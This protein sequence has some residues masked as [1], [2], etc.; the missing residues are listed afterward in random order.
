MAI[1]D[2]NQTGIQTINPDSLDTGAALGQ[3]NAQ[4]MFE[5]PLNTD[6]L[7][8]GAALGQAN[9]SELVSNFRQSFS[10]SQAFEYLSDAYGYA[11]PTLPQEPQAYQGPIEYQR[12]D[13][14]QFYSYDGRVLPVPVELSPDFDPYSFD[15]LGETDLSYRFM[16]PELPSGIEAIYA[17]TERDPFRADWMDAEFRDIIG[18]EGELLEPELMNVIQDAELFLIS[19][20]QEA[21]SQGFSS[22]E[23]FLRSLEIND[24]NYFA[25]LSNKVNE[26]ASLMGEFGDRYRFQTSLYEAQQIPTEF[27]SESERIQMG[28]DTLR[29]LVSLGVYTPEEAA[30]LASNPSGLLSLLNQEDPAATT[31]NTNNQGISNVEEVDSQDKEVD[32]QVG[33]VDS[34]GRQIEYPL[35]DENKEYPFVFDD[36]INQFVPALNENQRITLDDNGMDVI[37]TTDPNTQR[38]SE[39]KSLNEYP[40]FFS[41]DMSGASLGAQ[42]GAEFGRTIDESLIAP[43]NNQ[44]VYDL[45]EDYSRSPENV[46]SMYFSDGDYGLSTSDLIDELT[47]GFSRTPVFDMNKFKPASE[48]EFN[49]A[50]ADE[51]VSVTRQLPRT[52]PRPGPPQYETTYY[53]SMVPKSDLEYESAG[54]FDAS[55]ENFLDEHVNNIFFDL[56]GYEENNNQQS[57]RVFTRA[58]GFRQFYDDVDVQSFMLQEM[59]DYLSQTGKSLRSV[60]FQEKED[61]ATGSDS[62][63]IFDVQSFVFGNEDEGWDGIFEK[64]KTEFDTELSDY[65]SEEFDTMYNLQR[66]ALMTA[67]L[68]YPIFSRIDE[69][70]NSRLAGNDFGGLSIASSYIDEFGN[71]PQPDYLDTALNLAQGGYIGGIA[72]GMDDTIPATVDGSNPAALS[73][74][75]FVIPADVVSHLGDGNN[76]NGAQ[77]LYGFLDDVRM[78]KT[79]SIEQPAPIND[80]IFASAMGEDYGF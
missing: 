77:K 39:I 48:A 28:M 38:V 5:T 16:Q 1:E 56:T 26:S 79:G 54:L 53:I 6:S 76:Q 19:L 52:G 49:L 36:S 63:D 78:S 37:V 12:P 60:A 67:G 46:L 27:R 57:E 17:P 22:T 33:E 70:Y 14:P 13:G 8:T 11:T 58:P 75:E 41:G 34:Q 2:P 74:G 62:P 35:W 66:F 71:P 72:G 44:G 9:V 69:E 59:N 47:T 61:I 42:Q 32:S 51:R 23:D 31:D 65:T 20:N 45:G 25:A 3:A 29:D 4:S 80:G 55:G 50:P 10:P 15:Y 30:F 73:S 68:A 7:D 43:V 18:Y 40:D 24:P 21:A 64:M